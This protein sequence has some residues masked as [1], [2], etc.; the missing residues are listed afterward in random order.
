MVMLRIDALGCKYLSK[1]NYGVGLSKTKMIEKCMEFGQKDK[2][3]G[4]EIYQWTL[5]HSEGVIVVFKNNTNDK[6]LHEKLLVVQ[7]G[8][9]IVEPAGLEPKN[10]Y[11]NFKVEPESQYVLM[12]DKIGDEVSFGHASRC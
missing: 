1:R 10:D 7:K 6:V 9:K 3:D 5:K 12:F 11:L 8:L 4:H 2:K